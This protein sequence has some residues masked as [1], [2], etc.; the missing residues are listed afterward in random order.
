M[1]GYWEDPAATDAAIT[2]RWLRTGDYGAIE[3]GRL[4]L[5]GRRSDLILRGGENVYPTEIE[6]CL[7]EHPA[8]SR[9]P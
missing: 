1:L 8:S 6:Q 5:T 7:D 3:N 9:A 4:R 2:R